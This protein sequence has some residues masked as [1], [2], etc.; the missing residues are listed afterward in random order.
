[1]AALT[2][3]F[4]SYLSLMAAFHSEVPAPDL[5]VFWTLEA[6]DLMKARGRGHEFV[7]A[8]TQ[9][10]AKEHAFYLLRSPRFANFLAN[11]CAEHIGDLKTSHSGIQRHIMRSQNEKQE[12]IPCFLKY[13][14]LLL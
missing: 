5:T 8:T 9:F 7:Y 13:A 6:G 12:I 14:N 2:I 1:M 10:Q 4:L 3:E 11:V